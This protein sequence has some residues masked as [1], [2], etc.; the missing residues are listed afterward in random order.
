M[1]NGICY[2]FHKDS[3]WM[4][5]LRQN[6]KILEWDTTRGFGFL[7]HCGE[8]LF[9]HI[10]DYAARHHAPRKGDVVSFLVGEDTHGRPCAQKAQTISSRSRLKARHFLALPFLLF[11]PSLAA[12]K[13]PYDLRI[14]AGY[15]ALM[16]IIAWRAYSNDKRRALAGEW[17]ISEST[18]HFLDFIGGWPGAF[19]V[20]KHL[21]H[22]TSKVSFQFTFWFLVCLYQFVSF[23]YLGNWKLSET[24]CAAIKALANS[25][26]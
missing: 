20:Q 4:D 3:F 25:P 17:R 19:L 14:I 2:N 13:M 26:V 18:L 11:L 21:R 8:R 12:L 23:D 9:L 1:R 24:F 22:K 16:S 15:A 5:T 7:D 6:G 10:R